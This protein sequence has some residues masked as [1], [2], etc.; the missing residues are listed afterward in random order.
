[1]FIGVFRLHIFLCNVP[2]RKCAYIL[3]YLSRN[4]LRLNV[5]NFEYQLF[6][7]IHWETRHIQLST[8]W[9]LNSVFSK[10]RC[11]W[12]QKQPA[13]VLHNFMIYVQAPEYINEIK[14]ISTLNDGIIAEEDSKQADGMV[15]RNII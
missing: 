5:H 12:S 6:I 2:H 4:F 8:N 14:A 9:P 15:L 13:C 7:L 10:V 1:M 3:G 11:I